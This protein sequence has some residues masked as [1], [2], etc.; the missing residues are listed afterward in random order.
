MFSVVVV[1]FSLFS[2]AAV[3][4]SGKFR[5][6]YWSLKSRQQ[7]QT[8]SERS[9]NI[10]DLQ[11]MNRLLPVDR[12]YI[13]SAGAAVCGGSPYFVVLNGNLGF[14]ALLPNQLLA[15][16]GIHDKSALR[17]QINKVHPNFPS[18]PAVQLR[19]DPDGTK[20]VLLISKHDFESAGS[21][22]TDLKQETAPPLYRQIE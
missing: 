13:S 12:Q 8:I 18:V 5:I 14:T 19:F 11:G 22:L 15:G 16:I 21:C 4:Q 17:L 7:T 3:A 6:E 20:F 9:G 10:A 1:V 2:A